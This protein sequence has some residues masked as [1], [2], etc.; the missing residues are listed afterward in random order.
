MSCSP[1]YRFKDGS[2]TLDRT[3]PFPRLGL[4]PDLK[5]TSRSLLDLEELKNLDLTMLGGN[6]CIMFCESV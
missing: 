3:D 6:C 5:D 1:R 2:I 4:T